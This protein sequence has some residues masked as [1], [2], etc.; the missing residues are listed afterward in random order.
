MANLDSSSENVSTDSRDDS[1]QESKVEFSEDEE[2]LIA[3]MYNLVGERWAL[4]A[5]RIPGRTAEEIEK[6]WTA[7]EK[8]KNL[9]AQTGPDEALCFLVPLITPPS[10]MMVRVTT[11][12]PNPNPNP[13]ARIF[14]STT[15]FRFL[16]LLSLSFLFL[17]LLRRHSTLRSPDPIYSAPCDPSPF[18]AATETPT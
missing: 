7:S 1:S 2:T 11:T 12:N 10:P 16:T 17:S 5:G 9:K 3:R 4:I 18:S 8:E 6:Y 13:N 15:P 14:T